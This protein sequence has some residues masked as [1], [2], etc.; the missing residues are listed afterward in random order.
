MKDG[1]LPA[2]A[3][4]FHLYTRDEVMRFNR[5]LTGLP[6]I[7]PDTPPA[8]SKTQEKVEED[9]ER[10]AHQAMKRDRNERRGGSW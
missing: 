10:K 3:K 5:K 8:R 9:E 1:S 2:A 4:N 7:P 6:E